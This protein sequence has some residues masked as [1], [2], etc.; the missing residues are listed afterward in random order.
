MRPDDK[1]AHV[2]SE[3]P[4]RSSNSGAAHV[5]DGTRVYVGNLA[6]ETVDEDVLGAHPA[7]HR[8]RPRPGRR[9]EPSLGQ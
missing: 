2:K 8:F 1:P 9:Q 3:A 5:G 4:K 6:W 7:P